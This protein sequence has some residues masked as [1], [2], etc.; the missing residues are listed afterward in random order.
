MQLNTPS[1]IS[2]LGA[3]NLLVGSSETL[4]LWFKYFCRKATTPFE[5][6]IAEEAQ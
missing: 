3:Q 5:F 4:V 2:N 1:R 6:P